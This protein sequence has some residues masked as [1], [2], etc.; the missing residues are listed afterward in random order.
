MSSESLP[1][2]GRMT[3]QP[4]S[5]MKSCREVPMSPTMNWCLP[6]SML[7]CS[8]V[9][10]RCSSCTCLSIS[11]LAW[12][13]ASR[14]PESWIGRLLVPSVILRDLHLQVAALLLSSLHPRLLSGSQEWVVLSRDVP[15]LGVDSSRMLANDLLDV[16]SGH[17]NSKRITLNADIH[18]VDLGPRLL[19][20]SLDRG[21]L[22]SNDSA[23]E[24]GRDRHLQVL[25]CAELCPTGPLRTS[26]LALERLLTSRMTSRMGFFN[27]LGG[28]I[29]VIGRTI[30]SLLRPG[31][32]I[33]PPCE[34]AVEAGVTMPDIGVEAREGMFDAAAPLAM[35][36]DMPLAAL[37]TAAGF[38]DH[39][40]GAA[41]ACVFG[42]PRAGNASSDLVSKFDLLAPAVD[43]SSRSGCLPAA[44]ADMEG[45]A[46]GVATRDGSVL[47]GREGAA[48][49]FGG[50]SSS[51][52]RSAADISPAPLAAVS[53]D[54]V[55]ETITDSR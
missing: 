8:R 26:T 51:G 41:A 24:R 37:P 31:I 22:P 34:G 55:S 15:Q 36:L 30:C 13:T 43:C 52:A 46:E 6:R 49:G 25:A 19:G 50:M 23:T 54:M 9:S 10:W 11:A 29:I 12:A 14:S 20:N 53:A 39:G 47:M 18:H 17:L 42:A 44:L 35:P 48:D 7:I 2:G 3:E 5:A 40:V 32:A 28:V 21:T 45:S 4:V 33:L 1:S 38:L 27:W 16:L